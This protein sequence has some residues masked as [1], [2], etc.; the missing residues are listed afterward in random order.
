VQKGS[1]DADVQG[2]SG[3][4]ARRSAHENDSKASTHG[5]VLAIVDLDPMRLPD[6]MEYLANL[7]HALA[8]RIPLCIPPYVIQDADA[9]AYDELA[10]KLSA[11]I[12]GARF[13]AYDALSAEQLWY[14]QLL[15][16]FNTVD[17]G[18]RGDCRRVVMQPLLGCLDPRFE[19]VARPP[20][21]LD[22]DQHDPCRLHE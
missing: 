19:P 20:G 10:K 22:L 9:A 11:A 5:P 21:W 3:R 8:H 7:R 14:P 15:A 13:W 12:K 4:A 2:V 1:G 6:W 17:V 18:E 16:D